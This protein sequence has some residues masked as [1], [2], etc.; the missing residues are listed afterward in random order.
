MDIS[1]LMDTDGSHVRMVAPNIIG[2]LFA[3][4][5]K[6]DCIVLYGHTDQTPGA[7]NRER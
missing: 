5:P 1:Y 6:G 3:V 4:S 2:E 7:T